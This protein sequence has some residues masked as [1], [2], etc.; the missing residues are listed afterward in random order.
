MEGRT[1]LVSDARSTEKNSESQIFPSIGIP[2]KVQYLHSVYTVL[3]QS[4]HPERRVLRVWL[5]FKKILNCV[6]HD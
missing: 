1:L 2:K 6:L 3:T 5:F 4:L